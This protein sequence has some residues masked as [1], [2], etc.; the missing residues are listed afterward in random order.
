M[1]LTIM[2]IATEQL[3]QSG[4]SDD[5][6]LHYQ[7]HPEELIQQTIDRKQGTLSNTGALVIN[8]GEFT[9]RS[10]DDRFFVKDCITE[11][12]INWNK[13]NIAI[14][15]KYFHQLKEKMLHFFNEQEEICFRGHR[16]SG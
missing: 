7:L 5:L 2:T 14:D 13:F 1:P 11:N 3:L 8:T 16:P 6:I 15:E 12:A 9:G 10:P 4:F